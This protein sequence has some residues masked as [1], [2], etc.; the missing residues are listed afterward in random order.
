MSNFVKVMPRIYSCRLFSGHDD[1]VL[2][3]VMLFLILMLLM[4]LV[5]L[6]LT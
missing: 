3:M 6:M 5:I 4:L 1:G 2:L